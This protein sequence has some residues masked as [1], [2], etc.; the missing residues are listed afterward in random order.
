MGAYRG[1][2][3][4]ECDMAQRVGGEDCDV[5]M[6]ALRVRQSHCGRLIIMSSKCEAN[7]GPIFSV[8]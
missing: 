5:G 4:G 1:H 6:E 2:V 3:V 8:C 7:M